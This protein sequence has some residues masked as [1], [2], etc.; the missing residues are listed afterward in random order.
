MLEFIRRLGQERRGIPLHKDHIW[1]GVSVEDQKTADQR[2]P[3]L[4]QTPAVVRFVSYEPALGPVDFSPY[5]PI[6]SIGGVEMENWLHWIITGGESGPNARPMHPDWAR[7]A[8][9][10]CQ[11]AGIQFFFKQVGEWAWEWNNGHRFPDGIRRVGK[12]AASR[13]LDGREWNEFP[14]F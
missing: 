1:L 12:K 11:A 10:Q 3:L 9:D 13:L 7:S 8:R 5:L 6:E 14:I 4:L 2:I